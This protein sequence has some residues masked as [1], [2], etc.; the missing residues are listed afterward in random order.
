MTQKA[1][2]IGRIRGRWSAQEID[3][4]DIDDLDALADLLHDVSPELAVAFVEEDDEYLGIVRVEG[5]I[6]DPRVFLS[7]HRVLFTSALA[8][9]LFAGALPP[10]GRRDLD[11]DSDDAPAGGQ[12]VGDIDLLADLGTDADALIELITEEGLLP[13]DVVA[14]I[15]ERAGCADILDE[16]GS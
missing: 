2:A 4:D 6:S 13:A 1:S 3:L 5:D 14:A 16:I 12:P 8:D 11:D 9:R 7:D 10:V 15:S